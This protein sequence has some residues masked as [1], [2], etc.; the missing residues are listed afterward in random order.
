MIQIKLRTASLSPHSGLETIE[1]F[2]PGGNSYQTW[3]TNGTLNFVESNCERMVYSVSGRPTLKFDRQISLRGARE[4]VLRLDDIYFDVFESRDDA[5]AGTGR[6][7]YFASFVK[8]TRSALGGFTISI[9]DGTAVADPSPELTA[10]FLDLAIRW[11]EQYGP[12]QLF[13]ECVEF[14]GQHP[15]HSWPPLEKRAWVPGYCWILVLSPPVIKVLGGLARVLSEAP[16]WSAREIQFGAKGAAV[17]CQVARVPCEAS[18]AQWSNWRSYLKPVLGQQ[19]FFPR[20]A[21]PWIDPQ[22]VH[23]A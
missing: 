16:V 10:F 12:D 3:K 20:T 13:I 18:E 6:R 21:F 9:F 2:F 8:P 14:G 22:D 1:E 23:S 19:N 11:A 17:L 4:K 15:T 7:N 5:T